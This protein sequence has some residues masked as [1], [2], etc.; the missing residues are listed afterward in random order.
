MRTRPTADRIRVT[1]FDV[2]GPAIAGMRVLDLYAGTGAVG[3]EALS[4]GAARVVFVE[5]DPAA[6]RALRQ[7]L[8]ALGASR[9]AARVM[10]GD[11]LRALPEVAAQEA[12]FDLVFVDPP[13]ASSLA[14]RTLAALTS[15]RVCGSG[16]EIVV[17]HSTRS[18]LPPVEGLVEHRR[19]RRIGDTALTFLRT[20]GYTPDGSRP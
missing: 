16:A 14:A 7:N 2:L 3:I 9:A 13:Y 15:A 6:V 11:V 19:S 20:E 4:R 5:R 12:P 17:Q 8:S 18:A 10:T 1:L